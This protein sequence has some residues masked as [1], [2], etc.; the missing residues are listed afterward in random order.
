MR[1]KVRNALAA[2]DPIATISCAGVGI[3]EDSHIENYVRNWIMS[4]F[5][6]SSHGRISGRDAGMKAVDIANRAKGDEHI[7]RL[8]QRVSVS[9]RGRKQPRVGAFTVLPDLP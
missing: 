4:Y 6:D 5:H 9:D 3:V 7:A 2:V 1:I 8:R